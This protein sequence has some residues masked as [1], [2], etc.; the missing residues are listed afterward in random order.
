MLGFPTTTT[1]SAFFI[2][3]LASSNPTNIALAFFDSIFI[4]TPG[5]ALLSC[6]TIGTFNLLAA[7]A[8]GRQIYPPVPIII[9]GLKSC[10]IF[11][12]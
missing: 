8:T 1:F 7:R 5:N 2:L 11:F 3:F 12:A 4:A 9:S 6:N 10:I